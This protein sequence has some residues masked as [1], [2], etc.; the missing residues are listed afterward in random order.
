MTRTR[1]LIHDYLLDE[2]ILK[3]NFKDPKLDFGFKVIFPSGVD[4]IS[5]RQIGRLFMVLKPKNKDQI[6]INTATIISEKHLEI[7]EKEKKKEFFFKK[8][9]KYLLNRNLYYSLEIKNNRYVIED[10]IY[11]SNNGTVSKNLFF[12]SIRKLFSSS[13]YTI[14]L[15]G[16]ICSNVIDLDDWELKG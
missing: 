16:E 15:L 4:T 8:L 7:L 1:T 11:L 6:R 5:G 12:K 9:R 13:A 3:G 2:E 14:I 10:V